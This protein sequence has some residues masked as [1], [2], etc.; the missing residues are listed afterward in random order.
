MN[1]DQHLHK[2]VLA[3]VDYAALTQDA[4]NAGLPSAAAELQTSMSAMPRE[5]ALWQVIAVQDL[6]QRAGFVASSTAAVAPCEPDDRHCPQAA[7]EVLGLLLR[8]LHPNLMPSWLQQACQHGL[9]APHMHLPALLEQGMRKPE[10]RDALL[11]LLDRRGRW[12]VAQHPQW[13]ERYGVAGQLTADQ[14]SHGN[15]AERTMALRTMRQ[16]DARAALHALAAEWASEPPENRAGL[17]PCLALRLSLDDETFIEAALDDKR[18]EVRSEAQSLLAGLA[19]SQ[20][21]QRCITRLAPLV[22][23]KKK[24]LLGA[25]LEVELPSA[26][27]KAMTRDGIGILHP[28]KLGEKAAWLRDLIARV[29]PAHWS[30]SWNMAAQDVIALMAKH[31]FGQALLA[32][33][34]ESAT[35]SLQTNPHDTANVEW[36]RALLHAVMF[37]KIK[38]EFPVNLMSVFGSL[39]HPV[40]Q[41]LVQAWLRDDKSRW[42]NNSNLVDWIRQAATASDAPWSATISRDIIK[43]LQEG[44]QASEQ[45]TWRLRAAMNDLALVL[46]VSDTPYFEQHWPAADWQHWPQWRNI[47][48]EFL[49][50]LRFRMTMQRSFLETST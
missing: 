40:R 16:A 2:A 24:L 29:P 27:D 26:C 48:D 6:W 22:N 36:Y 47:V 50:T 43:R 4:L 34:I 46:D 25:Q 37:S 21:A 1:L 5:S 32:G 42:D 33:V 31:E 38:L 19:G 39:P 10:L 12:L 8:G 18:K 44:M 23:L 14:W 17:L 15:L 41:E 9:R 49:A 20:L 3:G 45:N 7:E 30:V 35:R 13:R 11:P 28:G